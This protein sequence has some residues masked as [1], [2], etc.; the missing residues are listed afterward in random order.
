MSVVI[1]IEEIYGNN[2]GKAEREWKHDSMEGRQVEEEMDRKEEPR[3]KIQGSHGRRSS[4]F[5]RSGSTMGTRSVSS[6]FTTDRR[7]ISSGFTTD[8]RLIRS[9]FTMTRK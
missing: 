9:G 1:L 3:I 8:R 7:L 6:G 4:C 2:V 5:I